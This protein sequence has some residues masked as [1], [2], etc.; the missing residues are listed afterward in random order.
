VLLFCCIYRTIEYSTFHLKRFG[1][2]EEYSTAPL[3]LGKIS[4]VFTVL[5]F[6]QEGISEV[7]SF[8]KPNP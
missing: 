1:N 7:I 4:D 5:T 2:I 6:C 8:Y 3:P